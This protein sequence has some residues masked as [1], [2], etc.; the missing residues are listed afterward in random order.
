MFPTIDSSAAG[1]KPQANS[2][3]QEAKK[4]LTTS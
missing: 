3:E 2:E 1:E 4:F